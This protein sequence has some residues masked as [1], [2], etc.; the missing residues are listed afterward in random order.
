[1]A[2]YLRL[3]LCVR[4]GEPNIIANFLSLPLPLTPTLS[5]GGERGRKGISPARGTPS[6]PP[7]TCVGGGAGK[8]PR[9]ADTRGK[10]PY[11]PPS[12]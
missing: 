3:R 1:M 10:A 5:H 7:P 12:R 4:A 11:A 8:A 9:P 2:G 6:R